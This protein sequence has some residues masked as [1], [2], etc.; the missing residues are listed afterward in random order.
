MAARQG[1]MS[2]A[3][4]IVHWEPPP[5]ALAAAG[6][7]LAA[8]AGSISGYGPADGLPALREALK[9]KLEEVNGLTGVS[10]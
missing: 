4:G 1:V 9:Q 3:Q 10:E 6:Q 2:L 8:E 7:L 5:R